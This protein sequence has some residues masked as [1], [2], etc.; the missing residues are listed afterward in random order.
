MKIKP[1]KFDYCIALN[2]TAYFL[3]AYYIVIFSFNLF[4]IAICNVLGFDVELF[5]NGFIHSGK[6][7]TP[8]KIILVFFVG[9]AFTILTAIGFDLL[10]R[11]QRK[12]VRGIKLL[13]LWIYIVSIVWFFGNIIVGAFFNFGIGAALRAYHVPFFLRLIFAIIAISLLVFFGI[14]TQKHIRVSANLYFQ[15]LSGKVTRSFFLAQIA[16]PVLVGLLIVI[17]LKLPGI[18]MYKFYDIYVLLS[19]LFFLA[20]LF[21]QSDSLQSISFKTYNVDN[22]NKYK[23]NCS[24][25]I[26]VVLFAIALMALIRLGLDSGITF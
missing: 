21:Y 17:L 3:L 22:T 7:W 4:S 15:K 14:R 8:G 23:K 20:G 13:Y 18:G 10:Y 24:F 12:Y 9:N 11:K 26:Y 16:F 1:T 19:F 6:Q 5:Y 25:S 2:S